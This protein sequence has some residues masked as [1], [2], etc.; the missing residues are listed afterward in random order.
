MNEKIRSKIAKLEALIAS[1]THE[2]EKKAA[3]LARNRLL[4]KLRGHE[5]YQ[6][7]HHQQKFSYKKKK[8]KQRTYRNKKSKTKSTK[9]NSDETIDPFFYEEDVCW[10]S[11]SD[12]ANATKRQKSYIIDLIDRAG[13]CC[14]KHILDNFLSRIAL[15]QASRI[16]SILLQRYGDPRGDPLTVNQ[17]NFLRNN[18]GF[19]LT[20]D[21]ID[22]LTTAQA[23]EIGVCA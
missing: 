12:E 10:R 7:T 15:R 6:K 9:D 21:L 2:G 3:I 17:E 16:L 20:D 4:K 18:R 8:H 13:L 22:K 23:S 11:K 14:P 19:Q 1:T 5:K